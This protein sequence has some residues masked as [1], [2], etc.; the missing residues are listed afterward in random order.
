M[1]DWDGIRCQF[2]GYI[3]SRRGWWYLDGWCF[4]CHKTN[5][6]PEQARKA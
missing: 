3:C 2:C 6:V 1:N 5:A 4:R